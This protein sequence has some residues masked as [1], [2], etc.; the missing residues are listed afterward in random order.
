[1]KKS[2]EYYN[3]RH[4]GMIK[5]IEENDNSLTITWDENDPVESQLNT[6]TESDFINC[7]MERVNDIN[8]EGKD[9]L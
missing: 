3:V 1:M 4:L 7:I 8:R 5:V 6:W 9:L 2:L